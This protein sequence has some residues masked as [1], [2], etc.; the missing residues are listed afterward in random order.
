MFIQA[1]QKYRF[2]YQKLEVMEFS[3]IFSWEIKVFLKENGIDDQT[4]LIHLEN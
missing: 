1:K 3:I 4:D 2:Q